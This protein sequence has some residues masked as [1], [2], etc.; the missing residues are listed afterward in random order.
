MALS[1]GHLCRL[2][3]ID[4][5]TLRNWIR[6]GILARPLRR[7]PATTY[8][9]FSVL[10]ARAA[11]ALR[12]DRRWGLERIRR[13]LDRATL[14]RLRELAGDAPPAEG[15]PAPEARGAQSKS[16]AETAP[17]PAPLA[18]PEQASTPPT[19]PPSAMPAPTPALLADASSARRFRRI[20]L[21]P[22]LE[23]HLAEDASPVVAR[24][25]ADIAA[26]CWPERVAQRVAPSPNDVPVEQGAA[27]ES[28]LAA[29]RPHDDD[30]PPPSAAELAPAPRPPR[31]RPKSEKR[32]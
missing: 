11:A 20:E 31:P 24:V 15:S 6:A 16:A 22:G 3:D 5:R 18:S 19:A 2:I 13:E 30:G 29:E 21:L 14:D 7:G 4:P 27:L 1:T 32:A 17:D 8:D 28:A 26:G 12:R 10:R 9:E 23:L 25:A